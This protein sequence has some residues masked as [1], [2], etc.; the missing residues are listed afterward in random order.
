MLVSGGGFKVNLERG[1]GLEEVSFTY[2]SVV[3]ILISTN[4]I[5]KVVVRYV[6]SLVTFKNKNT[7]LINNPTMVNGLSAFS[8]FKYNAT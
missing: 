7:D 3:E 1:I 4:Y 8:T 5:K 2:A 6:L